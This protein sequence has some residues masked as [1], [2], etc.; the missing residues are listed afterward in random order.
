MTAPG[1]QLSLLSINSIP[2]GGGGEPKEAI[3]KP[4]ILV[5]KK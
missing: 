1:T 5:L 3:G 4:H 2:G